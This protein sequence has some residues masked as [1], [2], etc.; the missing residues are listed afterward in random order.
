MVAAHSVYAKASGKRVGQGPANKNI[1]SVARADLVDSCAL[2]CQHA[3]LRRRWYET[4]AGSIISYYQQTEPQSPK[5]KRRIPPIAQSTEVTARGSH[6]V[7]SSCTL[8]MSPHT[9]LRP[10]PAKGEA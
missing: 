6:V 1:A 4:C 8:H 7:E 3:I 10:V 2:P 5:S 9:R